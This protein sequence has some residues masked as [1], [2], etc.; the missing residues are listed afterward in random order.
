MLAV[1]P[2]LR[3]AKVKADLGILVNFGND[4][5]WVLYFIFYNR[6]SKLNQ[7]GKKGVKLDNGRNAQSSMALYWKKHNEQSKKPKK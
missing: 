2:M 7:M 1:R 5:F 4:C 6:S 3:L